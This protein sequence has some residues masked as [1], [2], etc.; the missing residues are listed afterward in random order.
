MFVTDGRCEMAGM[1]AGMSAQAE[2]LATAQG[3]QTG[4]GMNAFRRAWIEFRLAMVAYHAAVECEE[5]VAHWVMEGNASLADL[6]EAYERTAAARAA[7]TK[8]RKRYIGLSWMV[9]AAAGAKAAA[10]A[11]HAAQSAQAA[12]LQRVG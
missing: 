2:R 11:A 1:T 8:A 5:Q 12:R 3:G 9:G 7:R 4:G 10:H 6:H